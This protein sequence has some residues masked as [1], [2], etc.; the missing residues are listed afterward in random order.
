[1]LKL[2]DTFF[3]VAQEERIPVT[4]FLMRGNR[5][6]GIIEGFD[7]YVV[8]LAS[9]EKEEAQCLIYK[10]AISTVIPDKKINLAKYIKNDKEE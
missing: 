4:I 2:Q 5:L 9:K 7:Q 8:V 10:H 1:M 3:K 6:T